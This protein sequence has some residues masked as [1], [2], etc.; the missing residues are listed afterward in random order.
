MI[1]I[2]VTIPEM[3]FGFSITANLDFQAFGDL[4]IIASGGQLNVL[5]A[6][7]V[8]QQPAAVIG[9]FTRDNRNIGAYI[10]IAGIISAVGRPVFGIRAQTVIT[11]AA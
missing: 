4:G 5:F 6:G 8:G 3:S 2:R 11:S 10:V 7:N 9:V 1:L